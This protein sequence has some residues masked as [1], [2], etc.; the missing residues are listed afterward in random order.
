M[1]A[2]PSAEAS[3]AAGRLPEIRPHIRFRLCWPGF[4][5]RPASGVPFLPFEG[6]ELSAFGRFGSGSVP[7]PV[8]FPSVHTMKAVMD[9]R[10]GQADSACG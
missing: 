9:C 5:H 1:V 10:V 2:A 6:K 7:F 8:R 4:F 3:G